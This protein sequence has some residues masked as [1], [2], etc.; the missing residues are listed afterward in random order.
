MLAGIPANWTRKLNV[1]VL[2]STLPERHTEMVNEI[3]LI[4]LS[5]ATSNPSALFPLKLF[6]NGG[7]P[8]DARTVMPSSCPESKFHERREHVPSLH[9]GSLF[10]HAVPQVVP[11]HVGIV[12]SPDAPQ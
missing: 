9:L 11:L 4:V 8:A 2:R 1:L 12:R 7:V 5:W 10:L 3:S 6:T